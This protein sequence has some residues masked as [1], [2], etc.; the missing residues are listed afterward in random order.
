MFDN[1][2]ITS[3]IKVYN[4]VLEKDLSKNNFSKYLDM[5]FFNVDATEKFGFIK[6]NIEN[7][8]SNLTDKEY[9]YY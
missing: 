1:G 3:I 8:K 5:K 9:I 4:A 2:K 7:N 6:E